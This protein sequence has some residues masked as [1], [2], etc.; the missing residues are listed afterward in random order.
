MVHG[1]LSEN[2]AVV[3]VVPTWAM[4]KVA[5]ELVSAV[6]VLELTPVTV[7]TM[8]SPQAVGTRLSQTF[9]GNPNCVLSV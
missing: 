5:V 1:P 3:P 2:E 6:L 9:L 4:V 8:G 7:T